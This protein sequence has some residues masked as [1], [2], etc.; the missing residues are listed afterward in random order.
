MKCKQ[1]IHFLYNICT[2]F[3]KQ[4]QYF[5]LFFE[6][7]Q[8]PQG[9]P[10]QHLFDIKNLSQRTDNCKAQLVLCVLQCTTYIRIC[11]HSSHFFFFLGLYCKHYISISSDTGWQ[12]CLKLSVTRAIKLLHDTGEKIALSNVVMT[13]QFPPAF[14]DSISHLI[15]SISSF[16]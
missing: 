14:D 7:L 6:L 12:A 1:V 4:Q 9:I 10:K 5:D 16:N 3:R 8:N 15:Q 11:R 2:T 13:L